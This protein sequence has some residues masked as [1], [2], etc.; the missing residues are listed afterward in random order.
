MWIICALPFSF[1]VFFFLVVTQ[2][3][4]Y[5]QQNVDYGNYFQSLKLSIMDKLIWTESA[6]SNEVKASYQ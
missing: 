1:C 5:L 3:K 4:F 6:D 2:S